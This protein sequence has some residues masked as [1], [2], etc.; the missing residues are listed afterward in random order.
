LILG[1][2]SFGAR[3]PVGVLFGCDRFEMTD[4]LVELLQFMSEVS[5]RFSQIQHEY[6]F[7]NYASR[8]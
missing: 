3:F 2:F 8:I 4:G 6:Q 1:N 5:D 7:G